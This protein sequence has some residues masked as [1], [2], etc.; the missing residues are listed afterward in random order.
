[1]MIV[2]LRRRRLQKHWNDFQ[3][4]GQLDLHQSFTG[5]TSHHYK[6]QYVKIKKI[7]GLKYKI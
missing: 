6:P 7:E 1:M 4:N 5:H 2:I 3:N